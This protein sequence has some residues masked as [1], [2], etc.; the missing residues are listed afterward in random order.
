MTNKFD[1]HGIGQIEFADGLMH[2][3]GQHDRASDYNGQ[4]TAD[5]QAMNLIRMHAV[6]L[7]EQERIYGIYDMHM[8]DNTCSESRN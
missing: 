8:K 4:V 7:S 1:I 2:F 5:T 6:S 3:A